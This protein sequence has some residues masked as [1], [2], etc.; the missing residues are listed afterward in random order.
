MLHNGKFA[1]YLLVGVLTAAASFGAEQL[2]PAVRARE[3]VGTVVV[4][5]TGETDF[6]PAEEGQA[7]SYGSSFRSEADSSVRLEISSQSSLL[8]LPSSDILV[9]ES[10]Q[11]AKVKSVRIMRGEV[12]ANLG[13]E[14]GSSGYTLNI[15][16]AHAIAQ[17]VGTRYRV[18]ARFDGEY[19]VVVIRVLSGIVRVL[20]NNFEIATLR[21]DQWLSLFG[22]PD[23]SF[24]RMNNMRGRFDVT[25]KN[26]AKENQVV[27]LEEGG[28]VKVW[29]R[30]V[31][32]TGERVVTA[33]F[34]NPA[35][36][37]IESVSAT[38][39]AG[40]FAG[41]VSSVR[42]AEDD[43]PWEQIVDPRPARGRRPRRERPATEQ[44]GE[45]PVP[46]DDFIDEL[47]DRTFGD[48]MPGAGS[49][50]PP[51]APPRPPVRPTPTPVGR[52]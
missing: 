20:A 8:V 18:A 36:E 50:P 49:T 19:H 37:Q 46:P 17:A 7:Y 15:E 11:N 1:G 38:F 28:E 29:Q 4:R 33:V 22:P 21:A 16:S 26:E 34:T 42:D 6:V 25:V 10:P 13:E 9:A 52:R 35:G 40:E 12:E 51:P 47:I 48:L 5:R 39:G 31:P 23:Q 30:M 27:V 32:G 24:L 14:F 41:F 2:H 44:D 45:N 43:F 3:L